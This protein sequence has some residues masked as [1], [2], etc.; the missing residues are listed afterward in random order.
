VRVMNTQGKRFDKEGRV[1]VNG[2]VFGW[3]KLVSRKVAKD[4]KA[5]KDD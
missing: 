2:I 5:R 1:F 4:R 3:G